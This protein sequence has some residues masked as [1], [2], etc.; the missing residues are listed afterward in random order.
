MKTLSSNRE[1]LLSIFFTNPDK[2]Y[3]LQEIGRIVGKKPGNFQ[4]TINKIVDEGI[5]TSEYKGNLRF[6]QINKGYPFYKELRKIVLGTAG[7]E[8]SLRKLIKETQGIDSAFIYGSF[9]EGKEKLES[10]LNLCIIGEPEENLVMN[11]I[12]KLEKRFNREINYVIYKKREIKEKLKESNSF[13]S[14]ILNRPKIVLKGN[15]DEI[16]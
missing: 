2:S 3:Y 1:L 5:L 16:R 7:L 13:V 12:D 9:A 14:N 15:I 6:F 8:Y 4:R 11:K 10:D